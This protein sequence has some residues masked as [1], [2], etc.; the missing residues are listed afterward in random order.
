MKFIKSGKKLCSKANTR[1]KW[2]STANDWQFE[3]DIGKQL[4][5]P[6]QITKTFLRPDIV[7]FSN[8]TKQIMSELTILWDDHI[9]EFYERE[10]IKIQLPDI[11]MP[12]YGLAYTL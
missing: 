3:V 8:S 10:I 1:T 2:L 5:F 12:T 11:R 9:E 4:K 6:E 7:I